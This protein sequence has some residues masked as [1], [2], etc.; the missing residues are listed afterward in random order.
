M[1][2]FGQ[3]KKVKYHSETDDWYVLEMVMS[4]KFHKKIVVGNISGMKIEKGV[5][6]GFVGKE[7]SHPDW[8]KQIKIQRAPY[9]DEEPPDHQ[10]M[11]TMEGQ[12]VSI[13]VLKQIASYGR[14]TKTPLYEL[15]SNPDLMDPIPGLDQYAAMVV[16]HKWSNIVALNNYMS[17]FLNQKISPAKA[18]NI[19][20][21]YGSDLQA[22]LLKNP[23]SLMK[24]DLSFEQCDMLAR[25]QNLDLSDTNRWQAALFHAVSNIGELGD[26]YR[27]ASLVMGAVENVMGDLYTYDAFKSELQKAINTSKLHIEDTPEGHAIYEPWC[28]K[29]ESESAEIIAARLQ[30]PI[31]N[32]ISPIYLEGLVQNTIDDEPKMEDLA[33]YAKQALSQSRRGIRLH[34]KQMEGAINAL[35]KPFSIITGLPGTGKTSLLKTVVHTLKEMGVPLLLVAPTGMAAKRLSQATGYDAQTVHRALGAYRVFDEEEEE[36]SSY[37]GVIETS[38]AKNSENSSIDDWKFGPNNHYPAD[39]VIVDEASMLDQ[40]LLW[41][42]LKATS[43]RCRFIL[44]GDSAQLPSVG[45]GDVLAQMLSVDS[46][47]CVKLDKIFRQD[48]ASAIV[49]AAHAIESGDMPEFTDVKGDFVLLERANDDDVLQTMRNIID[50]LWKKTEE[51]DFD[52]S[53]QV[54]SPRHKGTVGVTS[55]N[56][57]LREIVN[58]KDSNKGE[59]RLNKAIIREGDRVTVV[60][61]DYK[62]GVFNG[63]FG[64]VVEIK[65]KEKVVV[66]KIHGP[67]PYFVSFPTKNLAKYLRLAY[68]VTVHRSQGQEFDYIILPVV[69]SFGM[70]LQRNLIYTAITR[71]KSKVILVGSRQAV[72]K[73]I[74]NDVRNKRNTIFGKRI[75][76]HVEKLQ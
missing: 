45:A 52:K 68:S 61:N 9:F 67:T 49:K 69:R 66:V 1:S 14:E 2:Y 15:L 56:A 63:D 54:I 73:S 60:K 11:K 12:G 43:D 42:L 19:I 65:R 6:F 46:I 76:E 36:V 25:A 13:W 27:S 50:R 24:N 5:W 22:I 51:G 21:M 40:H 33:T 47:P 57:S 18:K 55:L 59:L 72:L 38:G 20:K 39:V 44:V 53:Y 34:G 23:W 29:V 8:G 32:F 10:V 16:H 3:V 64:K 74:D 41:R 48:D 7:V 62:L 30:A 26:L 4:G 35:T 71:A 28:Y 31:E 70:Q 37:I 58:P 75:I 17:L